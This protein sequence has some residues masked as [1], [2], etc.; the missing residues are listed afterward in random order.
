MFK[1]TQYNG[2]IEEKYS[3]LIFDLYS[4]CENEKSQMA[5]LSNSSALLNFFLT[6]INW[7]GFYLYEKETDELVLSS[8]QGLP[9]CTR[10]KNGNGVCGTAIKENKVLRIDDVSL[11]EGHIACDE[12]S[13]SEIVIPIYKNNEIFGV[14]DIDS[15]IINRFSEKDEE[16][17]GEFVRKLEEYI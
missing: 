3:K 7:V 9:A 14:L 5:N 15:P 11:F 13:K 6:D 1:A 4:L 10:I 16:Y 2:T 12:R 8:F 17:L